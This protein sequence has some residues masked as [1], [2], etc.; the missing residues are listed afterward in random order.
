[1]VNEVALALLNKIRSAIKENRT[2]RI[3]V[4]I[5]VH[6]EGAFSEDAAIRFVMHFQYRTICRGDNSLLAT[7]AREFPNVDVNQY[8]VFHALRKSEFLNSPSGPMAVTEQIYVHSKLM[9]VDDRIALI[10]SANINDRSMEGN[11]DSEIALI[12]EDQE[13][14]DSTMNGEAV[15]VGRFSHELRKKLWREHLGFN[16]LNDTIRDPVRPAT[17]ASP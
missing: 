6:P 4:I 9:I 2:F 12:V 14:I 8:I 13:L 17:V 3:A 7:L 15:K 5:P 16:T 10:G 11:R 1:V